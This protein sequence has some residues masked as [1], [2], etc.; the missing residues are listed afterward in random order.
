M[1]SI[2]RRTLSVTLLVFTVSMMLIGVIS[3]VS[4]THE[5][6]ELYD[7]HLAQNARLLEG[8][9]ATPTINDNDALLRRLETALQR[10]AIKDDAIPGHG[11]E[12]KFA[13]QLW[14]G[15]TLL[16]RSFNAPSRPLAETA[17]YSDHQVDDDEWRVYSLVLTQPGRR[18][19]VAERADVRGELIQTFA[20]RS[21]IPDLIGLPIL[22]LLLWY[23][24][25]WGLAPLLR[26]TEQIANRNPDDLKPLDIAPL[27][28]ELD[29]MVAAL[30]RL[31]L[32]IRDL[33][34]REKRFI[35]DAAHELRTPLAVMDLHAQ[36][37]LEK[38]NTPE[39]REAALIEMRAGVLR[40][41]RLVSQLLTLARLEPGNEDSIISQPLHLF[42]E[43]Q[44]TL[45]KLAPLASQHR[46][47][48]QL[49]AD[50]E[51]SW[52]ITAE[53]GAIETLLQNLVSNALQHSPIGG[54]ITVGL[55][56]HTDH[57]TLIVADEGP[58]I[59]PDKREQ[60]MARFYRDSNNGGAGLGLSIVERIIHRHHGTLDMRNRETGGLSVE[61]TLPYVT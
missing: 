27:P 24:I 40:T 56:T 58:G 8:L 19:L 60:V 13:F 7:A 30:N 26:L 50:P 25:G 36:N 39:D 54:T 53:P 51:A 12:G 41:T 18:I 21:L 44:E 55:A 11:Y 29:T 57:I 35:A 14:E 22:A 4:A 17:G 2:R 45:A 3:Y 15:E 59:S 47:T 33:R 61:I 37:A 48:L 10:A 52:W 32:R 16:L 31:M 49:D 43:A 42:R 6:E 9:L 23:A 20:F 46:Q 1:S 5:I 38:Q 34:Q 28:C